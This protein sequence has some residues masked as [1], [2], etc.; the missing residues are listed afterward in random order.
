MSSTL[1]GVGPDSP[2]ISN[3]AGGRQS[4]VPYDLTLVDWPAILAMSEVLLAAT[5]PPKNYPR[6]NWRKI[7]VADH[8][9]HAMV[10]YAAYLSGDTS[11]DHLTHALCR[12]MFAVA[13]APQSVAVDDPGSSCPVSPGATLAGTLDDR[14]LAGLPRCRG[15]RE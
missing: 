15:C 1:K 9:N 5:K 2:V 7:P 13:L 14:V 12:A 6:G 8:V 10:H 3:E 11:D 4:H